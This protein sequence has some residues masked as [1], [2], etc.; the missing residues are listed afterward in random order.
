[1]FVNFAWQAPYLK[2]PVSLVPTPETSGVTHAAGRVYQL[3]LPFLTS[4]LKSTSH[5][6]VGGH[7]PLI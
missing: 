5:M 2:E 6:R 1:M 7:V 3:A 4:P